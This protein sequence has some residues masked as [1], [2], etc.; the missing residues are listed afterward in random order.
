MC[1]FSAETSKITCTLS[2]GHE[3]IANVTCTR[4]EN[5]EYHTVRSTGI[6]F[7]LCKNFYE[8]GIVI[9]REK[10]FTCCRTVLDITGPAPFPR[11][12]PLS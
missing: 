9:L 2:Y 7:H 6:D 11:V 12:W 3:V 1:Q 8:T 10:V 5:S 4:S